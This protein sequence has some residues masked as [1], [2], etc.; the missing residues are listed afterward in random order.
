MNFVK[1]SVKE[2]RTTQMILAWFCLVKKLIF[3]WHTQRPLSQEKVTVWCAIGKRGIF[4]PY[5]FEDNDGNRVTVNAERYIEMMRRKFVPALRRKRGIDINTVVFQQ[6]GAPPHCSNR[7]LEF[8]RQY[9]PGDRLISRRTDNPWTPYSPDLNPLTIFCGGTWKT[10]FMKTIHRQ[11]RFSKTTS[12][13]KSDGFW[14]KCSIELWTIL[15]FEL[16]LSYSGVV[17]GSNISLITRKV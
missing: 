6:D 11:Q 15:M 1:P 12:E 16:L 4:G 10:E 14:K 13:E 3:I 7:T 8:L 17:L 9:F 2:L 5:I